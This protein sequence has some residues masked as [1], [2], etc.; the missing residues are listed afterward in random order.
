MNEARKIIERDWH[1]GRLL[2][3]GDFFFASGLNRISPMARSI[4]LSVSS[5]RVRG[6]DDEVDLGIMVEFIIE[7]Y[8]GQPCGHA[9]PIEWCQLVERP[10]VA[11]RVKSATFARN[12]IGKFPAQR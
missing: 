3:P 11:N 7:D 12:E 5:A 6:F 4:K 1:T 10:N 2:E 8:F 9:V